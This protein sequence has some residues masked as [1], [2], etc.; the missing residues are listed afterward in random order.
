[1][2]GGSWWWPR[3]GRAA[4]GTVLGS[5]VCGAL[6]AGGYGV[7]HDQVTY[8]LSEEYFT[9]FKFEQFAG[10]D[11][12]GSPRWFVAKIGFAASWW[13]GLI[14]GWVLARLALRSGRDEGRTI[15][16]G[17]AI[18]LGSGVVGALGGWLWAGSPL[19]PDPAWR[20]FADLSGVLDFEAFR[21]VGCIHNGSYLGGVAGTVAAA[22][23]IRSRRIRESGSRSR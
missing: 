11:S 8:T 21:R 15:A 6:L 9:R 18:V 12:G 2:R 4:W 22:L 16:T 20:E 10:L 17:F 1:M 13:V 23:W 19:T 14:A 5:A 3:L 7:L